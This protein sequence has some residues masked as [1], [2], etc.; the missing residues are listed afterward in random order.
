MT[1]RVEVDKIVVVMSMAA[2]PAMA[3]LRAAKE[4][5]MVVLALVS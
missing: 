1:V 5:F 3:T 2:T 4:V